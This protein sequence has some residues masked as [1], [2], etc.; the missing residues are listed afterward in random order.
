M[1]PARNC[2]N[3]AS[4]SGAGNPGMAVNSFHSSRRGADHDR[5]PVRR[6]RRDR[7]QGQVGQLR[8][9]DAGLEHHGAAE[10][11][12]HRHAG[13]DE[14]LRIQGQEFGGRRVHGHAGKLE[15][16]F[17]DL[18][19]P[20]D[21]LRRA[22]GAALR[23]GAVEEPGRRG[24]RHQRAD[25]HAARRLAEDG[26]AIG[27]APEGLDGCRAPTRGAFTWSSRPSLP[28]AGTRPPVTSLR[29]TKPSAPSR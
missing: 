11:R 12:A 14:A 19:R 28:V 26:H 24:E 9:I 22:A 18:R 4:S 2:R 1:R 25:T 21:R 7:V 20:C 17:R 10:L 29:F 23:N 27:I 3:A 5:N 13:F 8:A 6:T 15:Q 16:S